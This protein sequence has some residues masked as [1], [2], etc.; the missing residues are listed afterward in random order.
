[1]I[2]REEGSRRRGERFLENFPRDKNSSNILAV[3]W[4]RQWRPRV[5]YP[6][7][8]IVVG[9]SYRNARGGS[10]SILEL[11]SWFLGE[12]EEQEEGKKRRYEIRQQMHQRERVGSPCENFARQKT[13]IAVNNNS[14]RE[15]FDPKFPYDIAKLVFLARKKQERK[16]RI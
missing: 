6:R 15:R 7:N 12:W 14:N 5:A 4:P 1:M 9:E 16:T 3:S 2:I 11:S 13:F 10:S 8:Y